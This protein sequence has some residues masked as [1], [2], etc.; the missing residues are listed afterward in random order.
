MTS[1]SCLRNAIQ[2]TV[3]QTV[4]HSNRVCWTSGSRWH[5][6]GAESAGGLLRPGRAAALARLLLALF[7]MPTVGALAVAVDRAC[8][9]AGTAG[10]ED[11]NMHGW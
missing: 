10:A 7:A 4:S 5:R 9:A 2:H 1:W 11:S 6:A 8:A 3:A